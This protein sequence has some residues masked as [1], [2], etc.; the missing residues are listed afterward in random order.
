MTHTIKYYQNTF[1]LE[2]QW[3]YI[4]KHDNINAIIDL[5]VFERLE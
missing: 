2:I 1:T 5:H 3:T 4:K